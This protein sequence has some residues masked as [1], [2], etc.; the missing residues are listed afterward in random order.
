MAASEIVIRNGD[1]SERNDWRMGSDVI[2]DDIEH[3]FI[4]LDGMNEGGW[5]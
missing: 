1:I 4:G 5:W 3:V 2:A